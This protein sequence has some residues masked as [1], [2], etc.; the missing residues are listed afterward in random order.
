MKTLFAI[1]IA[2]IVLTGCNTVAGFGKDVQ[3][4][5]QAVEGAGRK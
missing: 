4:V 2:T 3:K 5:G 1:A